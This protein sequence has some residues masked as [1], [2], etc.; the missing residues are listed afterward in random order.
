MSAITFWVNSKHVALFH[1]R[2]MVRNF[3]ENR[4]WN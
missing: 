1:H 3:N 2:I 4:K